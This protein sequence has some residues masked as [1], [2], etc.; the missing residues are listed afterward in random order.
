MQLLFHIP[1]L[2]FL[3]VAWPNRDPII[4]A[5]SLMFVTIS[6]DRFINAMSLSTVCEPN[7][8]DGKDCFELT[9]RVLGELGGGSSGALRDTIK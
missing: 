5:L 2:R 6:Q 3:I 7:V 1:P 4:S 9:L 8:L